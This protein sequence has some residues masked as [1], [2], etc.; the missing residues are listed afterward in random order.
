MGGC[1]RVG[2][3]LTCTVIDKI[4]SSALQRSLISKA[5]LRGPVLS[6]VRPTGPARVSNGR[7]CPCGVGFVLC[8]SELSWRFQSFLLI[9][10]KMPEQI[11][12]QLK[13]NLALR[14]PFRAR[15]NRSAFS[16]TDRRAKGPFQSFFILMAGEPERNAW[17]WK[18]PFR[19]NMSGTG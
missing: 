19:W 4:A 12:T 17:P 2:W 8:G 14:L 10:S 9:L 3:R 11:M 15:R 5:F 13:G 7:V 1:L 18:I 6:F 16:A